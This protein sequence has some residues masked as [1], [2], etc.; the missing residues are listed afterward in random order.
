MGLLPNAKAR[1]DGPAPA[2]SGGAKVVLDGLAALSQFG[3]WDPAS[4]MWRR[5]LPVPIGRNT[6]SITVFEDPNRAG[7]G[8]EFFLWPAS[9]ILADYILRNQINTRGSTVLELGSSHGL[10]AMAAHAAGAQRVV[11]TDQAEVLPFLAS[12]I[13]ANPTRRIDA[14]VLEWGVDMEAFGSRHGWNWELVMGSDLTFNRDAFLP[15]LF[16]LQQLLCRAPT[17]ARAL[18][19]HDDDSVPGGRRLRTDF[20]D[21]TASIYFNVEQAD[22]HKTE[23]EDEGHRPTFESATVHSYWL[24]PREGAPKITVADCALA[25]ANIQQAREREAAANPPTNA[26]RAPVGVTLAELLAHFEKTSVSETTPATQVDAQQLVG[27]PKG[28]LPKAAATPTIP[29][30]FSKASAPPSDPSSPPTAGGSTQVPSAPST[31]KYRGAVQDMNEELLQFLERA[32]EAQAAGQH[33]WELELGEPD[34]DF[35]F[36]EEQLRGVWNPQQQT[37]DVARCALGVNVAESEGLVSAVEVPAGECT[38]DSNWRHIQ[39]DTSEL[40]DLCGGGTS[41]EEEEEEEVVDFDALRAA[42][43]T[44]YELDSG[45]SASSPLGSA[46]AKGAKSTPLSESSPSTT[47]GALDTSLDELD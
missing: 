16:T 40:R 28:S 23:Q 18:L 1:E 25:L 17:R 44:R 45:L 14:A 15:L 29:Q 24:S 36:T 2:R 37:E 12:N 4:G 8:G 20:F 27:E 10:A 35:E 33:W 32:Q 6:P 34:Y 31:G 38:F 22:M 11:A 13:A 43:L 46:S 30:Q 47:V 7:I 42:V 3:A 41:G 39:I 26:R 19:L 5:E 21:K 9:L